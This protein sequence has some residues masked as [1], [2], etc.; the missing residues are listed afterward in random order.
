MKNCTYKIKIIKD[1]KEETIELR[2]EAE[3]DRFLKENDFGKNWV[4]QVNG[5]NL[6]YSINPQEQTISKLEEIEKVAKTHKVIK[7]E[8][9]ANDDTNVDAEDVEYYLENTIGVLNAITQLKYPGK[10]DSTLSTVYNEEQYKKDRIQE[11][12]AKGWVHSQEEAEKLFELEKQS[13]EFYKSVGEEVHDIFQSIIQGKPE[14]TRKYLSDTV[15]NNIRKQAKDFINSIYSKFGKNT[16]IYSEF[17][18][19]SKELDP[20]IQTM[21]KVA[22]HVDAISGRIDM[23]VVDEKGKV[24]IYDFKVSRKDPGNWIETYNKN[25]NPE[26]WSSVKKHN[27]S[28]QMAFY[29]AILRQY[30]I[31]PSSINIVP[32]HIDVKYNDSNKIDAT[33]VLNATIN[34]IIENPPKVLAGEYLQN[35]M[36]YIPS[37][38][39]FK[40]LS[41]V[42]DDYQK[43]LP[44][45]SQD[46]QIRHFIA[47]V[48]YYR[49]KP[50]FVKLVSEKDK[51]YKEQM[52]KFYEA[53]IKNGKWVYAKDEEDLMKKL[54]EYTQKLNT[55]N[56]TELIQLGNRIKEALSGKIE[57]DSVGID[58]GLDSNEFIGYQ[59]EKYIKNRWFFHQN[60]DLNAAGI[61]VFSKDGKSEIVMISE[62]PLLNNIQMRLGKSLLGD[63]YD[64]SRW[65]RTTTLAANNG[66]LKLIQALCYVAHNQ[67]FFLGNKIQSVRCINPWHR[68]E[69]DTL[70]STLI[71]NFK[72]LNLKSKAG[73]KI[74]WHCFE[75]D[76]DSL[77][78][79]ADDQ[80]KLLNLSTSFCIKS[81]A[82][83]E[84]YTLDWILKKVNDLRKA[85]KHLNNVNSYDANDPA[86]KSLTFLLKA[87]MKILGYQTFN[88]IDPHPW[89]TQGWHITAL[90]TTSGH[91]SPSANMR[92]LYQLIDRYS[93]EVRNETLKT[94]APVKAAFEE[95]YKEKG[96][97]KILGG[98][99]KYFREWFIK[100]KNGKIDKSFMLVDP[101]DMTIP[102][103]EKSRNALRMF[104]DTMAYLKW[105]DATPD[106]IEEY[107][108]TPSYRMMPILEKRFNRR[109]K[110]PISAIKD[111]ARKNKSLYGDIFMNEEDDRA[112]FYTS[113]LA[114]EKLYNHFIRYEDPNR[115]EALIDKYGVDAL[116]DDVERV[117]LEAAQV[118]TRAEIS[119]KYLPAIN[120]FKLSLKYAEQHQHNKLTESYKAIVDSITKKIFNAPIMEEG[121]RGIYAGLSGIRQTF[122]TLTLGLSSQAF[123]REMLQ[124]FWTQLSRSWAGS[125]DGVNVNTYTK[126]FGMIL[127][128]VGKNFDTHGVFPQLNGLYGLANYSLNDIAEQQRVNWYG[129]RNWNNQTLFIT[130]ASPDFQHRLAILVAKML[131]DGCYE[132]S[133]QIDK[134]GKIYYDFKKDK[135]FEAYANNK[136]DDPQYLYQKTLYLEMLN[137][138]NKEGYRKEDGSMLQE[139]DALPR[140]YTTEQTLLIKQ[141]SDLMYGHYDQE[142]KALIDDSFLGAFF[143]QF[144]TWAIAGIERWFLAP[145]I[146]NGK[147]FKQQY[148]DD[149]EEL[150]YYYDA[151]DD[152]NDEIYRHIVKKSEVPKEALDNNLAAPLYRMEGNPMEGIFFSLAAFTKAIFKMDRD[153]LNRLWAD[154]LRRRNLKLAFWDIL[155]MGMFALLMRLLFNALTDD[156]MR[157]NLTSQ[158][159]VVQWTYGVL[160]GSTQDGQIHQLLNSMFGD[161]NPPL[162][163]QMKRA[164]Q[165]TWGV[166][167]GDDNI[168]YALT[169]QIGAIRQFQ[170]MTKDLFE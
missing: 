167:T 162:L 87:Y 105:P 110:H 26:F 70:N 124:G 122:S 86:W 28:Y 49:Y 93:T 15:A 60:E 23:L 36:T 30:G 90:R 21:L 103:S 77:I 141:H 111:W 64:D 119:R 159:W 152:E 82:V 146:Y 50:D 68:T 44:S 73:I 100:D 91:N 92:M 41:N 3:L 11:Y 80:F 96:Q 18:I 160:N 133:T 37:N 47:D 109:L 140:A 65:D 29:N 106:E 74:N 101:N 12:L 147:E 59:F 134:D 33:E 113:D 126:A 17:N 138:F 129:L 164:V 83:K 169:R 6:V 118:Y 112:E 27:I 168:V 20:D 32:I 148:S 16:K 40:E 128:N 10:N 135:R 155:I 139:G 107:K 35:A 51:Y 130:S 81:E 99:Y 89:I 104:L 108:N 127:G 76:I 54:G 62:K 14:K 42:I 145:G 102:L 72:E 114:T 31:T 131:G 57:W 1:G 24:H 19:L 88:E 150:W 121:L 157:T 151:K 46:T 149:G 136:Y 56:G 52:F 2:N 8:S 84:E 61:F 5:A 45:K 58:Y 120:G 7:K 116:E 170:G 4:R 98:E 63:Y 165:D 22:N 66:N 161:L 143:M 69:V 94:I 43:L 85:S 142:S 95:F 144:R 13:W 79:Q 117:F 75:G 137:Q 78:N 9:V 123:A 115:R 153:E 55:K 25:I 39:T 97:V 34:P 163:G 71:N 154:P 53:N 48:N 132:A 125:L 38:P 156:D 166:I 67:E 158:N